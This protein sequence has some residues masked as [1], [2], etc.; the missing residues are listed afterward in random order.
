MVDYVN[1][2]NQGCYIISAR[3]ERLRRFKY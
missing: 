1:L 3:E 2:V